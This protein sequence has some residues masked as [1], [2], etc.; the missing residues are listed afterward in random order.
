MRSHLINK[1]KKIVPILL[2][3]LAAFFHKL[4]ILI[5]PIL[6]IIWAFRKFYSRGKGRAVVV[7]AT[8]LAM[9]MLNVFITYLLPKIF[10]G[11]FSKFL[12]YISGEQGV[13]I[14]AIITSPVFL[15]QIVI[16]L[17]ACFSYKKAIDERDDCDDTLYIYSVLTV[18]F[19]FLQAFITYSNRLACFIY[20]FYYA[21]VSKNFGYRLRIFNKRDKN[22]IFYI[23]IF[24]YWLFSCMLSG[25]TSTAIYKFSF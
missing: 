17:L 20:P 16:F 18:A 21:F 22:L 19:L 25:S 4:T 9:S 8:L 6:F 3:V 10:I 24:L 11:D 2:I 15:L 23:L 12:K 13:G 1:K 5:A 7:G 14:V